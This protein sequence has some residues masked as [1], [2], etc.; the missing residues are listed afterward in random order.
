MKMVPSRK[1]SLPQTA[2]DV[3]QYLDYRKLLKD[4]YLEKKALNSNFSYRYIS[5]KTGIRSSGYFANIL[6]GKSNISLKL[7]LKLSQLFSLKKPEAEYF[8]LLVLFNQSKT[9]D[10]KNHLFDRILKLKKSK[11][12]TLL[13]EYY[14]YFNNWYYVVIREMLDFV[15]FKGD[16]ESLAQKISPAITTKEAERA[17]VVLESLGLIQKNA[18]GIYERVD[19]LVTTGEE[20]ESTAIVNFQKAT[21]DLAKRSFDAFPKS[22]RDISTLT[23]SISQ[24][25]LQR[26]KERIRNVRR[27]ILEL[28]KSDPFTDTVYQLE[29]IAFPVT[30]LNDPE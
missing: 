23:I 26:I 5:L 10:E 3:Y 7:V 4:L 24:K 22:A 2:I 20:V 28:A 14:E 30:K 13:P 11:I 25:N 18:K 9:H 16:Y 12:K 17:I 19:A 21:L 27:E 29:F 6:S 15:P 1:D 8:E